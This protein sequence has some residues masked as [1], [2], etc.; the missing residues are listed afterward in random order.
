M[1]ARPPRHGGG[2]GQADEAF[3]LDGVTLIDGTGN[4]PVTD[5][6]VVVRGGRIAHAGPGGS[7]DGEL[8][9]IARHRLAGK[10]IIPGLT[11][12][13]THASYDSDMLAY[14]RNGVTTLRFAGLDER[15][16]QGLKS[17]IASGALVGPRILSC[18]PM[19]DAPPV[20]YPEWSVA[21][22]DA[23]EAASVA[24]QLITDAGVDALILTQ[25]VTAPQ[26][27]A[28]C[29]VAHAHG[30]RVLAQTWQIDG[31]EAARSGIDEVHN[32][33]RVFHSREYPKERLLAYGSIADRLALSG[34]GWAT[35]DWDATQAIIDTMIESGVVYC[36]MQVIA[37][38]QLDE[39]VDELKADP[40]F[41]SVFGEVERSNFLA[42]IRKL[43]GT[44][45]PEDFEYWKIANDNRMEWMRR[46]RSA[47]GA[48]IFGT[49]MQFGGIMLHQEL[50]NAL[51]LG[52]TPLQVIAAATGGAARAMRLQDEFGTISAGKSADFVV[53]NRDPSYDL[54]ALRDI[55][56]VFLGG[57]LMWS[58]NEASA[59]V[60]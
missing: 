16:V 49:D 39:G 56:S 48:L 6:T 51:A 15:V 9:N 11:E 17:R 44:W 27:Q 38:F 58:S 33:S 23:A 10:T 35:I 1:D 46:F 18:G 42:F 7:S 19:I 52:M 60:I 12:A 47:G 28:V 30:R 25:R 43:Q 45:S 34:R 21:V 29:E 36:G 32:S 54:S 31:A 53:L 13:H 40:T 59:R 14:V 50:R 22:T 5:A 57:R 20:A 55:A 8:G 41:T 24:E 4:P 37:Q 3:V 2:S 26:M